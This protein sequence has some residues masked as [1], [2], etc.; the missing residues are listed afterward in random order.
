MENFAKNADTRTHAF[1]ASL[2]SFER[3]IIHEARLKWKLFSKSK[4]TGDTRHL[5][6]SKSEIELLAPP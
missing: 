5:V 1:D 4:G 3:R 6:I 2:T